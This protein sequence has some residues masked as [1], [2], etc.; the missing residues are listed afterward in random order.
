[1]SLR[2]ICHLIR[3]SDEAA[4]NIICLKEIIN[5]PAVK[6]KLFFL[7]KT[8]FF[9]PFVIH[10]FVWRELH[11]LK[12]LNRQPT[13]ALEISKL[14]YWGPFKEKYNLGKIQIDPLVWKKR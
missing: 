7:K 14:K 12:T 8:G 10:Q 3:F 4:E 9:F 6:W 1:M 11:Q 2:S 5:I 13:Q